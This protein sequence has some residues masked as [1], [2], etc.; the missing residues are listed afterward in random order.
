MVQSIKTR[1]IKCLEWCSKET[2]YP[3]AKKVCH[4]FK[5]PINHLKFHCAVYSASSFCEN[6]YT[7]MM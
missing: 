7:R 1:I 2:S 4:A 5:Q 6:G 3:T